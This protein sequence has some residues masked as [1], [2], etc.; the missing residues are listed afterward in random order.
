MIDS[1]S[2]FFRKSLSCIRV[3]LIEQGHIHEC[4]CNY[5]SSI[6]V[7]SIKCHR[8]LSSKGDERNVFVVFSGDGS[9]NLIQRSFGTKLSCLVFGFNWLTKGVLKNANATTSLAYKLTPWR[10]TVHY[11]QVYSMK[12]LQNIIFMHSD[13]RVSL[14]SVRVF[15]TFKKIH[16]I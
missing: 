6:Y 3:Q 12:R 14:P 1:K 9:W 4:C 5:H 7:H 16:H 15:V 13:S 11:L 8:T 2:Y 10:V